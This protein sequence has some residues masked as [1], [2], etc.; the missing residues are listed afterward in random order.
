MMPLESGL[1]YNEFHLTHLWRAIELEGRFCEWC[2]YVG[3]IYRSGEYSWRSDALW[4][5]LTLPLK[6][7][8]RGSIE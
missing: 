6:V 7:D 8:I 3:V 4:D 2:R 5:W 1:S